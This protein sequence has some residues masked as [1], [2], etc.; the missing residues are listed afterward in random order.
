VAAAID[1]STTSVRQWWRRYQQDG[2]GGLT[3][4]SS[5]PHRCPRAPSRT[6]RRQISH[7]RLAV[8]AAIHHV[9]GIVD[10]P[11]ATQ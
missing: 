2:R 10:V 5:R 11:R 6:R 8:S 9:D 4:R 1:L 7:D 3:D